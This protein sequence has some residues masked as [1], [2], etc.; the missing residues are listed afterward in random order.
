MAVTKALSNE[1]KFELGKGSIDFSDATAGAF[2]VILMDEEANFTFDPD[3]MGTYGDVSTYELS[4]DNGYTQ[5]TKALV[6]DSA[7]AQDDVGDK[8]SIAWENVTWTADTGNI[9][10]TSAAIILAYDSGTA[11]N[12]IVIGCISFGEDI[13][14]EDGVSF[15]LQNLGFDLSQAA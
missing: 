11:A 8:G 13:T 2:R 5:I 7:W 9:G 6:A 4:T 14:I 15:Q 1:F 12:S 10:P 3:T